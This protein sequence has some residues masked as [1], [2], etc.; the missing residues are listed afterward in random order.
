MYYKHK[1]FIRTFIALCILLSTNTLRSSINFS[2][3]FNLE[4]KAEDVTLASIFSTLKEQTHYKFSYS[5]TIQKD[6]T[7]YSVHYPSISFENLMADLSK[8]A[9]FSYK[10]ESNVVLVKKNKSRQQTLGFQEALKGKVIDD[11][12]VP[13]PG[14]NI[15]EL[16]TANGV[17]T[18]FDGNF[19]LVPTAPNAI[20]EVSYLGFK[21]KSVE[22][23]GRTDI[24]ITLMPDATALNEV[25]AIGYGT[26]KKVNLTGAVSYVDSKVFNDRPITNLTQGLQGQLPNVEINFPTGRPDQSG[27]FNIRGLGSING[28]SPLVLI[29]GVPGNFNTLNPRDIENISVL[30]DAASSSIYGARGAFGVVLITTKSGSEDGVKVTY[31]GSLGWSSPTRTPS[32]YLDDPVRYAEIHGQ[33]GN[34]ISDERMAYIRQRANDPSLPE[35]VASTN[36]AGQPFWLTAGN[37]DWYDLMYQENAPMN[38]QNFGVSGKSKKLKYYLSGGLLNQDGIY[39]MGTDEYQRYNLRGKLDFEINDWL[40]VF[41]NS[42]YSR[43]I[44]NQPNPYFR[45]NL[46]VERMM[47][48]DANPYNVLKTPEGN[49]TTHGII[50]GF[51]EEG[52]RQVEDQRIFRNT[53]GF[54]IKFLND[55]LKVHGDYTFQSNNTY[56]TAKRI[57][58]LYSP[59]PGVVE[60]FPVQDANTFKRATSDNTFNVFNVQSSYADEIGK[61]DFSAMLGFNQEEYLN[62]YYEV[63]RFGQVSNDYSSL[64]LSSGDSQTLDRESEYSL[65]GAF[66]R[67]SYSYDNRYLLE[68]NGRYDLSSKFPENVRSG[69]FPS[70]SGAWRVS[71]ESFF[72]D[73][74]IGISNLKIRGSYGSLGNQNINNYL[75]TPNLA[76]QNSTWLFDGNI[77]PFASLP[78]PISSQI[79]WE[80]IT[81]TNFGMDVGFFNGRLSSSFD[82][83]VRSTTDMLIP[84]SSLPSVYGAKVPY[85]NAGDLQTK[86]WELSLFWKDNFK[87]LSKDFSY[88]FNFNIGDSKSEI[89]KFDGNTTKGLGGWYSPDYYDGKEVGEIWGYTTNGFFQSQEELDTAPDHRMVY[90]DFTPEMGDIKFVDTNGDGEISKEENTLEKHGD[91]K[92]IGNSSPRYNYGFGTGFNWNGFDFSVFFQGIG[93]RDFAPNNEAALYYGFYN[94]KYQPIFNHIVNDLWST[95]NPGATFPN[96]RGYIA[97]PWKDQP[98]SVNQTG[99]LQDASYLRWKNMIFGYTLDKEEIKIVESLRFYVSAENIMEWTK[100][101][102]AFD[103]E[104]LTDDPFSPGLDGQGLSY[105]LSRKLSIGIQLVF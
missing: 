32:L 65:R 40:S 46:N 42:E 93:K 90:P 45:Y 12:G 29:D 84:G 54:D 2:N 52:G 19:S 66:Y 49:W 92:V 10:I 71:E 41:N 18:D 81:S 36:D 56:T 80:K 96:P 61:H 85:Q 53:L 30:K 1:N 63:I 94:R 55:K 102:E 82:Y 91:L 15:R 68:L 44:Y 60:P 47:S 79:T 62:G 95:E 8:K 51:M 86:G 33:A 14:A 24:K 17:V 97:G 88:N 100:L 69:F 31:D 22:V 43:G 98:L 25:V 37:T 9:N 89:T 3:Q 76:V 59:S 78:A 105:P 87:F 34:A 23:N 6:S 5:E 75:Y 7:T 104:A 70:I 72:E 4:F 26:K 57:A 20:L 38:I 16:N 74:K 50:L 27:E 77:S 73:S 48:Q 67:L 28:G 11:M 99:Q 13:L 64:N 83:F 35:I 103:P 39:K 58:P 21:T 101:S